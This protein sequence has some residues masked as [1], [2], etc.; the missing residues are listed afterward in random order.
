MAD[1]AYEIGDNVHLSN[2][3]SGTLK[4]IGFVDFAEGQFYGIEL[5]RSHKGKNDGSY[6]GKQYFECVPGQGLFVRIKQVK[7]KVKANS[8]RED[9]KSEDSSKSK[10]KKK[11]ARRKTTNSHKRKP[12]KKRTPNTTNSETLKPTLAKGRQTKSKSKLFKLRVDNTKE[13]SPESKQ[14]AVDIAIDVDAQGVEFSDE[15]TKRRA[16][17]KSPRFQLEQK[18]LESERL[19]EQLEELEQ[20]LRET[21]S[22]LEE[23]QT[24]AKEAQ[25]AAEKLEGENHKLKEQKEMLQE[26]IQLEREAN[27]HAIRQLQ[28][29]QEIR[30]ESR[31]RGVSVTP[32]PPDQDDFNKLSSSEHMRPTNLLVSLPTKSD[33]NLL[34]D[35]KR[36]S[37][38]GAPTA[39]SDD[40]EEA[41]TGGTLVPKTPSTT[42]GEAP[43]SSLRAVEAWEQNVADLESHDRILV[44]EQSLM[45]PDALKE[46]IDYYHEVVMQQCASEDGTLIYDATWNPI[47]RKL[48]DIILFENLR[49]FL[50]HL[51]NKSSGGDYGNFLTQ[52]SNRKFLVYIN[53]ED[54]VSQK[55]LKALLRKFSVEFY[56]RTRSL[57]RVTRKKE[58]T[59]QRKGSDA[60]MPGSMM[61]S[62]MNTA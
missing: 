56:V 52:T 24:K 23:S 27:E 42:L 41:G 31:S 36:L 8:Q 51:K 29:G 22:K 37:V 26:Q 46:E 43:N 7:G 6:G 9:T 4:F 25:E 38:G 39:M 53:E 20:Q 16:E 34:E 59:D 61:F 48:T 58:I 54:S 19:A 5:D 47:R 32:A 49:A 2:L 10:K 60:L 50:T 3:R 18:E 17:S 14:K 40:E 33:W 28:K 30:Q 55:K 35:K 62:K 45:R 11:E 13:E 12:G 57:R 1:D 44:I 21:R 15:N